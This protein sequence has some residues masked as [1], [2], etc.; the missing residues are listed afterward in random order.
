M[1]ETVALLA[2]TLATLA[3]LATELDCEELTL[4]TRMMHQAADLHWDSDPRLAHHLWAVASQRLRG[5]MEE[6]PELRQQLMA[7]AFVPDSPAVP[8]ERTRS[9]S[10]RT[11]RIPRQVGSSG[12]GYAGGM[13]SW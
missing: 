2:D 8:T 9:R 6:N 3:E 5:L 12:K 1:A 13:I 11:R 4:V 7:R 10:T